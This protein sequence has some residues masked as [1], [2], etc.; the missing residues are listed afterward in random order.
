MNLI[1]EMRELRDES[2]VSGHTESTL[3]PSDAK[4]VFFLTPISSC[5]GESTHECTFHLSDLRHQATH[6]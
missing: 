2:F 3:R 1:T 6:P 4:S 5:T